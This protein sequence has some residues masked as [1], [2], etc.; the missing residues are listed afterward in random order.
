VSHVIDRAGGTITV[1]DAALQQVVSA[2][3]GLVAGA[4]LRRRRG[5]EVEVKAGRARVSLD[6]AAP[7]GAVLPELAR[8]VQEHVTAALAGMCGLAVEAVDVA[9]GDLDP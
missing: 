7:L 6:L 2:A 4:R 9:I 8:S 1:T 3:V 5:L